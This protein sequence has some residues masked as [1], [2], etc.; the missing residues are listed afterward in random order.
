MSSTR[1]RRRASAAPPWTRLW[2]WIFAARLRIPAARS[3]ALAA[4]LRSLG[5]EVTEADW[6]LAGGTER[7]VFHVTT[8]VHRAWLIC[9]SGEDPVLRGD[10]ALLARVQAALGP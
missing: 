5:A 4:A 6:Q 7:T 3:D 1:W 2:A 10:A 9:D 8:G